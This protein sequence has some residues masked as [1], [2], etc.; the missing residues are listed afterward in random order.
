ML[1]CNR[2][3]VH[4]NRDYLQHSIKRMLNFLASYFFLN[5]ENAYRI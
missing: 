1:K 2:F 5:Y 4:R 3:F